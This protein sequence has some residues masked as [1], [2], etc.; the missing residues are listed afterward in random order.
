MDWGFFSFLLWPKCEV[1]GPW[2]QVRKKQGSITCR[3]DWANKANQMFIIWLCWLLRFWKGTDWELEVCTATYGPG[4]NQSQH[5][6]SVSYIIKINIKLINIIIILKISRL[7]HLIVRIKELV[8]H[9][10]I[11]KIRS[12]FFKIWKGKQAPQYYHF[13][14]NWKL[15]PE[16]DWNEFVECAKLPGN[17]STKWHWE[18]W[19]ASQNVN[20]CQ[21]NMKQP[22]TA[23]KDLA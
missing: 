12:K 2:K 13:G 14:T 5:M 23:V 4:I 11:S 8:I 20:C 10:K 22:Q 17:P 18:G 15:I 21:Q 1:H 6:K 16:R 9:S 7:T 19:Q 3:M